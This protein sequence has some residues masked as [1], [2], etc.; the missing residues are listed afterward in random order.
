[1]SIQ[2][3]P[4]ISGIGLVLVSAMA[5]A[6]AGWQLRNKVPALSSIPIARTSTGEYSPPAHELPFSLEAVVQYFE[7]SLGEAPKER[8]ANHAVFTGG[9]T[10]DGSF[11]IS[12]AGLGSEIF[13]KF[14]VT[15]DYG[16]NLVREFFEAPFFQRTESEQLYILLYMGDGLR[17]LRLPRFDVVFEFAT[18]SEN[19][20]VVL[21]FVPQIRFVNYERPDLN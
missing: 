6:F 16:M 7:M 19:T 17:W 20:T 4:R 13:V 8:S 12:A 2:T 21:L 3:Y 10:G 14:T 1:M 15:D 11:T 5:L 9:R 18:D